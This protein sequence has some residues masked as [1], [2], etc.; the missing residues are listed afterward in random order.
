MTDPKKIAEYLKIG[1]A[2]YLWGA[3]TSHVSTT[4]RCA[5]AKLAMREFV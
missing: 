5:S 3:G 4:I 2:A 1:P